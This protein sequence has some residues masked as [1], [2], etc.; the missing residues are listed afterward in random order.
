MSRASAGAD[1]QRGLPMTPDDLL[2]KYDAALASHDW[3]QVEPLMHPDVCVIKDEHYSISDV[4][5][6]SKDAVSRRPE[7]NVAARCVDP[8]TCESTRN[9][10]AA[11][12]TGTNRTGISGRC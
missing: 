12:S 4:H 11:M 1:S 10:E 5:W 3:A 8:W 9:P 2:R 7:S 6:V